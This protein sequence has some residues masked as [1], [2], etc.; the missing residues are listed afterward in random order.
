[1]LTPTK[2]TTGQIISGAG[3]PARFPY[4]SRVSANEKTRDASLWRG[5]VHP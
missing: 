1:M 4:F 5:G 3:V 2:K